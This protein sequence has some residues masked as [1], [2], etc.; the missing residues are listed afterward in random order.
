VA[1]FRR[2]QD[3]AEAGEPQRGTAWI[4]S[5]YPGAPA[6]PVRV[7]IPTRWFGTVTAVLLGAEPAQRRAE[8][9]R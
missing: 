6:I 7:D 9:V 2:D 5:P 1:G 8:L 4:A 3:R